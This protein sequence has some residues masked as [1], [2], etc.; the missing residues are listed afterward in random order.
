M[1]EIS[2]TTIIIPNPTTKVAKENKK[3]NS[4]DNIYIPAT[5]PPSSTD[6]HH[7]IR[8]GVCAMDKKAKS[9]PMAEILSRFDPNCTFILLIYFLS[10]NPC[11]PCL[12]QILYIPCFFFCHLSTL[13]FLLITV[14]SVIFFGDE[15]IL[16][17]NITSWPICNVLVAFFSKGYPLNKVIEYVIIYKPYLS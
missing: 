16:N 12:T 7:R 17:S 6:Q 13:L 14:F 1:S 5:A 8:L 9:K 4:K 10:C 3:D 15:C 2:E 11:V